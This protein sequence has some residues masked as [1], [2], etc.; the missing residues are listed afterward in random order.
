[1]IQNLD[2]NADIVGGKSLEIGFGCH[3]VD[4]RF[5]GETYNTLL[6]H[7]IPLQHNTQLQDNLQLQQHV[8]LRNNLQL[9]QNLQLPRSAR[10]NIQL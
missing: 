8:K 10:H 3:F 6:R 7:N 1:M 4:Q 2:F 9:Q 5:D